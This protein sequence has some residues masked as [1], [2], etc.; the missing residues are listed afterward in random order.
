MS[1]TKKELLETATSLGLD[2]TD[3]ATKQEIIDLI[4]GE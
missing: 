4:K 2:V 3:R 1:M